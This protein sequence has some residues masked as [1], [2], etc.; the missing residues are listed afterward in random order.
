MSIPQEQHVFCVCACV[1]VRVC[2]CACVRVRACVHACVPAAVRAYV[3]ACVR[4]PKAEQ[5]LQQ[6]AV[7]FP[8]AEEPELGSRRWPIAKQDGHAHYDNEDLAAAE[9]EA[10]APR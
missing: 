4:K 8:F 9:T 7:C 2:V 1:R 5:C 3:H 10:D 6:F